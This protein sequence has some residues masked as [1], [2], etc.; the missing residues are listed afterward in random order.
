MSHVTN[1]DNGPKSSLLTKLDPTLRKE[2]DAAIRDRQPIRL[3]DCHEA[4][5][6]HSF[7]ISRS[8]FYR[9]AA[10]IREQSDLEEVV[11]RIH[12]DDPDVTTFLPTLLGRRLLS[13]LLDD[14][15]ATPETLHRLTLAYRA[16]HTV[17]RDIQ[18]DKAR[19]PPADPETESIRA[20]AIADLKE[21]SEILHQR[22]LEADRDL[23]A[24]GYD[25]KTRALIQ[26][27]ATAGAEPHRPLGLQA[28]P[29][30]RDGETEAMLNDM[31]VPAH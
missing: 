10:K 26:T 15:D 25:P 9:Y 27:A 16:A 6:L 29:G 3:A 4:F 13:I 19:I 1:Y 28:I 30:F 22:R 20:Q 2:L 12:P 7:R 11:A 31:S 5:D 14:E 17:H 21:Y 8:A 24:H 23:I 18:R